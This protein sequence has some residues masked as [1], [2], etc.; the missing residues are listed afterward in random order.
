MS[1]EFA[2]FAH[3]YRDSGMTDA[4]QRDDFALF[5]DILECVARFF[6]QEGSENPLGISWLG[7]SAAPEIAVESGVSTPSTFNRV[8][9]GEA[10]ETEQP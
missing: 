8:A 3:Y 9:L 4:Q 10:T 7:D 1:L 2:D 6:W 5:S